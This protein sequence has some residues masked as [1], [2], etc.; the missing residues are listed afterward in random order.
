MDP[1]DINHPASAWKHMEPEHPSFHSAE[2]LTCV[3]EHGQKERKKNTAVYANQGIFLYFLCDPRPLQPVQA[4]WPAP[5]SFTFALNQSLTERE[6]EG[7]P[8][9][10]CGGPAECQEMDLNN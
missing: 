5:Q 6:T 2:E 4:G 1:C 8:D 10:P 3:T 9:A 7:V